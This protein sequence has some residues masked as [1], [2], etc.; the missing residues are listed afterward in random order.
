MS[1]VGIVKLTSSKKEADDHFPFYG[2]QKIGR[3]RGLN[4][5][6]KKWRKNGANRTRNISHSKSY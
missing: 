4:L 2:H 6:V 5:I 3:V 1:L